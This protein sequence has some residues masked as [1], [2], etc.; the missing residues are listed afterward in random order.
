MFEPFR[1][2]Y[3]MQGGSLMDT[4]SHVLV[5]IILIRVKAVGG[6]FYNPIR[7]LKEII[8]RRCLQS[9]SNFT[10]QSFLTDEAGHFRLY[11]KNHK[12]IFKK[13]LPCAS[14]MIRLS[15][16][17]I[18]F[19]ISCKPAVTKLLKLANLSLSSPSIKSIYS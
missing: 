5:C 1:E 16:S 14:I 7:Q 8:R 4:Q 19:L 18:F 12:S 10:H 17:S 9:L 13:S 11:K 3:K 6:C 2:Y 15:S